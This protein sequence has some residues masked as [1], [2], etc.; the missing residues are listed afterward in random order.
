M[1]NCGEVHPD[2]TRVVFDQS[3]PL[4]VFVA[5]HDCEVIGLHQLELGAQQAIRE[6]AV[7]AAHVGVE[8][9]ER[10]VRG[11]LEAVH[12]FEVGAEQVRD[13]H[14]ARER[15]VGVVFGLLNP[16]KRA[17]EA[18]VAR[19]NFMRFSPMAARQSLIKACTILWSRPLVASL[20]PA[21]WA[22]SRAIATEER[23]APPHHEPQNTIK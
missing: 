2:V 16:T 9:S 4:V 6:P 13:K 18:P 7:R 12:A 23:V 19:W 22:V 14:I 8:C 15:V 11:V 17:R 5:Q 3:R 1:S 21:S 10:E 20:T